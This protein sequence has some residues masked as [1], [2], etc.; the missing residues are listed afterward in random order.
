MLTKIL[1]S[2]EDIKFEIFLFRGQKKL[3]GGEK[4]QGNQDTYFLIFQTGDKIDT[5]KQ[6]FRYSSKFKLFIEHG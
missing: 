1:Q 4:N 2:L 6:R 5:Y 3:C